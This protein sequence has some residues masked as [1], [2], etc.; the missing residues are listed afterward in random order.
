M[1]LD[2]K[3]ITCNVSTRYVHMCI[4]TKK[5]NHSPWSLI[6]LCIGHNIILTL[7]FSLFTSFS[8]IAIIITYCLF[9]VDFM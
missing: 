9:Y 4:L 1:C 3:L 7:R 6:I 2:I 8:N 5:N